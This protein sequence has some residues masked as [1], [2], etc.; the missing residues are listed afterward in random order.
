MYSVGVKDAPLAGLPKSIIMQILS[1]DIE[2]E[3]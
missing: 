3:W 1:F 2:V